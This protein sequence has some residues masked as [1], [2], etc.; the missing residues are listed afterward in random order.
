LVVAGEASGDRAAAAV[1]SQLRGVH[2]FG[3]GGSALGRAGVTIVDDMRAWTALGIGEVGWRA[4]RLLRAWHVLA[5]ATRARKPR[6]A[7]L[8]NYTEFNSWLAPR[9]H[10][11]GVRVLWYG[12]PQVWA[13]RRR[14]MQSLRASVDRMALMLPFE[15]QLWR[16][17]GVDAYYVGHPA[18]ETVPLHREAA[19]RVLAMKPFAEAVALLPGSR[20][21]E[22]RR[23]LVP[24]LDAFARVRW[25][26]ANI[27]ARVLIAPSLDEA[28]RAWTREVCRARQVPAFDVD[29]SAGAMPVLTAFDASVCA[30]GTVSLEA[31]LARAAPV[32]TYRVGLATELTARALLRTSHVALPNIMLGRRAFPELLQRDANSDRI[33]EALTNVL[34][35]R[36]ELLVACDRVEDLLG[37][38]RAPSSSIARVLE[39]WLRLDAFAG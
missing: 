12:A 10:R 24:M 9:L 18:L 27:D 17:A 29:P 26:R 37:S 34:E 5:A 8:V 13:W 11:A 31:T 3:L 2:A 38:A 20:P 7:L 21:H 6:A 25:D 1:V 14:R 19:R 4:P 23:L 33:A 28:T 16:Q 30:S 22:V 35:R 36:R 15:E 39:P 32:V